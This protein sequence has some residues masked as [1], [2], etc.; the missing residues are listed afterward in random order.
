MTAELIYRLR[1]A[2]EC[3][4]AATDDGWAM[5]AV[6]MDDVDE[7]FIANMDADREWEDIK[8]MLLPG[9]TYQDW[10]DAYL[11][12]RPT[13]HLVESRSGDVRVL[14]TSSAEQFS[15]FA[16]APGPFF[17]WT[18]LD[19]DTWSLKLSLVMGRPGRWSPAPRSSRTHPSHSMT[20]ECPVDRVGEPGGRRRRGARHGR[21]GQRRIPP[22]RPS[23]KPGRSSRRNRGV[24]RAVPGWRVARLLLEG[25]AGGCKRA[26]PAV[27]S[28]PIE[29][30]AALCVGG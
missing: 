19:G 2:F 20:R 3:D 4:L 18:E 29:L 8:A 22:A 28:Q 12:M 16:A 11:A 5:A 1:D 17:A 25:V 9:V 30:P 10:I 21:Y 7:G 23:P 15:G 27:A 14:H 13:L 6:T 24:L 26:C